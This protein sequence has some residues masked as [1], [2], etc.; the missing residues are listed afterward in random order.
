MGIQRVLLWVAAATYI[1]LPAAAV[2]IAGCAANPSAR[3]L[4]YWLGEWSVGSPGS[5]AKG[6]SRVSLSLDKCL[7]TESWGSDTS[8]HKGENALAYSTEEKTWYGLFADN[9]GRVHALK[10]DVTP[11]SAELRGPGRD[12]DGGAILK[13]V[14]IVRVDAN[15]VEQI[16]EKSLDGGGSWTAEFRMEY[17]RKRP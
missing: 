7:L 8:D 17:A 2:D 11:G 3:Q 16:W 1:V 10:G 9:E 14:R 15:D 12:A 13:R 5:P 4:D 6:H